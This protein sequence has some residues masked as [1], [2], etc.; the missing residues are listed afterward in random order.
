MSTRWTCGTAISP[1]VERFLYVRVRTL[2]S[3]AGHTQVP[4]AAAVDQHQARIA[5]CI[6]KNDIPLPVPI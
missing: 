3:L 4:A 1:R 2:R 6:R 5:A